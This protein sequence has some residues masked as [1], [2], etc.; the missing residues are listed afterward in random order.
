MVKSIYGKMSIEYAYAL[1]LQAKSYY[2]RNEP[3]ERLAMKQV[4][5]S[6]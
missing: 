6:I 4:K 2:R 3:D 1:F 5:K